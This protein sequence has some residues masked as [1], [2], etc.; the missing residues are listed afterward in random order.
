MGSTSKYGRATMDPSA[1]RAIGI[2]DRCGFLY[3]LDELRYQLQWIGKAI[4]RYGNLRV[5]RDC[6]DQPSE[7]LR[8]IT[9]PPDPRP[10]ADPRLDDFAGDEANALTLRAVAVGTSMFQVSAT[11][12]V[13]LTLT[14]PS[15]LLTESG[16]IIT[17]ESGDILIT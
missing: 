10:V 1:P 8:A 14:P 7:F 4:Q 5:C 11:V 12:E 6:Y 3:D 2:C 9:I 17:T 16:D 13:S 15:A